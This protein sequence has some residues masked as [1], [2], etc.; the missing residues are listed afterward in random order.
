MLTPTQ[1]GLTLMA[2]Q[3]ATL[4]LLVERARFAPD[5]ARAVGEAIVMETNATRKSLAT[6]ADLVELN[7]ATQQKISDLRSELK[8]DLAQLKVDIADVRVDMARWLFAAV[9]TQSAATT[10]IV[11]FMLQN[12]R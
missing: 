4:D 2:V 5:V 7:L 1:L 9:L 8:A 12:M 10:G 3:V 6:K 11:Y